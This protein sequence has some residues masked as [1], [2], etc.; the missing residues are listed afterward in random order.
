MGNRT[1]ILRFPAQGLPGTLISYVEGADPVE[2][3]ARGPVEFPA[4]ARLIYAT[5]VAGDSLAALAELPSDVFVVL[6]LG[7]ATDGTIRSV[8][9]QRGLKTL[10]L[11]GDFTDEGVAALGGLP[12]LINLVLESPRFTGT[13]LAALAGSETFG[14]LRSLDL[15][16]VP[17]LDPEQLRALA[18][19]RHLEHLTVEKTR[20]DHALADALLALVPSL[21]GV[22]LTERPGHALDL[23]VLE[24]LLAA[25]LEVNG[26]SAPPHHAARFAPTAADAAT[27][28]ELSD[29]SCG[30]C[31]SDGSDDEGPARPRGGVLREVVEE[32]ELDRLLAGPVP[33]LIGLTAPRCGPCEILVPVLEDTV[34]AYGAGLAGV[35]IDIARAEWARQRFDALGAPTVVLLQNGREVSRFSGVRPRRQIVGWLTAAGIADAAPG[36]VG[37]GPREMDCP[38]DRG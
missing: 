24:R 2:S 4:G 15:G 8:A 21:S 1:R 3:E 18:E 38:A 20:V 22:S 13:G 35:V 26:V 29:D 11:S 14:S 34:E 32:R 5:D 27:A 12:E 7:G 19:A 28:G 37:G 17:A 25:G 31:D 36:S 9:N 10:V 30:S 33:V 23:G 16:D 6:D